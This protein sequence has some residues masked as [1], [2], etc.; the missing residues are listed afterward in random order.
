MFFLLGTYL[1]IFQ[2][3]TIRKAYR[4][5]SE[6]S[7]DMNLVLACATQFS[8]IAMVGSGPIYIHYVIP[9]KRCVDIKPPFS[10]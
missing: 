2:F 8:I 7:L 5:R 6:L 10:L 3:I 9:W 4:N 1:R